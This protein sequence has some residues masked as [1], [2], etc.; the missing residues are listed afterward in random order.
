MA[1]VVFFN[2]PHIERFLTEIRL[3][4]IPYFNLKYL[5]I[6]MNIIDKLNDRGLFAGLRAVVDQSFLAGVS[7]VHFLSE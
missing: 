5:H 6:P 4:R 3:D 1:G 2:T 7:R